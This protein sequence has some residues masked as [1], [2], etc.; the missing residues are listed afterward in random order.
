MT[1]QEVLNEIG[2]K[3]ITLAKKNLK[4]KDKIASGNLYN[5]L[6]YRINQN[7]LE[8]EMASYALYV[9]EGRQPG[10]GIPVDALKKWLKIKGIDEKYSFVINRAIKKRGIKPT[11]FFTAAA[12]T[13]E[14]DLDRLLDEY[15]NSLLEFTI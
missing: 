12:E 11:F 14:K 5:S 6:Q 2:E 13:T 9:D 10:K 15:C 1:L 4:S 3:T 8:Y 7:K